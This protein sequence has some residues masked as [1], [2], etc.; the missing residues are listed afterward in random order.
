MAGDNN[1]TPTALS[2]ID[3][4]RNGR[5]LEIKIMAQMSSLH[6]DDLSLSPLTIKVKMYTCNLHKTKTACKQLPVCLGFMLFAAHQY[7]R[8]G[9]EAFKT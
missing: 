2:A 9:N 7:L 6:R 8:F 1:A 4:G 3:K 5:S